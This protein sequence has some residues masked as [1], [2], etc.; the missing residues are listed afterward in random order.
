MNIDESFQNYK[1]QAYK[2][3]YKLKFN[4]DD[5]Y[6]DYRVISKLIK[7]DENNQYGF[8]MKKP[9]ATGSIKEKLPSWIEFNLL[10][11][12][13][14]LDDLIGHLFVVDIEFD[15]EKATECQIMYNQI[16]LPLTDKQTVVL[17]NE[18]FVF[19][20]MELYFEDHNGMPKSYK[21]T[22]KCHSN[23]LPKRC[24]PIYLEELKFAIA[25]CGWKVTKLYKYYY[26]EQERYKREFILTNQKFRQEAESK[27]ESDFWKLLSNS[28][29][30]YDCRNNLG[31]CYFQPIRDEMNEL[32]FIRRYYNNLFDKDISPFITS[33]ILEDEIT[34]KFND[35]RQKLTE[36]DPFFS[37]KMR[38]LE[39]RSKSEQDAVDKF[40]QKEKKPIK[41][42]V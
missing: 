30:G 21:T 18:S 14:S 27:I 28:N 17:P 29:F 5:K 13:V 12:K 33:R 32:S 16:F 42:I 36:D 25:R 10:M 4:S 6:K 39:N 1:N 11:E 26:F 23:L 22:S 38:S 24:V 8:V 34:R 15:H 37:V 40:K 35:E 3:G 41:E 7:F 2:V 19:Q 31:N 9:M 20:L